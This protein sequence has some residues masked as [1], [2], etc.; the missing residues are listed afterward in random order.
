MAS[1][2]GGAYLNPV[3]RDLRFGVTSKFDKRTRENLPVFC[4][5]GREGEEWK[6]NMHLSKCVRILLDCCRNKV[7]GFLAI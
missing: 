5:V 6:R 1:C 7:D 4:E 2:R 3:L